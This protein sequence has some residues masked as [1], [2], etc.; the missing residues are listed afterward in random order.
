MTHIEDI[1][2]PIEILLDMRAG[3]WNNN[4]ATELYNLAIRCTAEK[5]KRPTMHTQDGVFE[6]L[7]NIQSKINE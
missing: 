6:T 5:N 3:E 7:E 2:C 4:I 1:E